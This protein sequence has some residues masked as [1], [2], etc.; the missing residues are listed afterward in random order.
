MTPWDRFK[1]LVIG[2]EKNVRDPRIFHRLSLIAF[3]AWVGLGADGLSSSNYGPQEA[4][5]SLG[6][7]RHLAL[8]LAVMTALTVITISLSYSQIIE[9]FPTGGGGYVVSTKLLGPAFGLVSGCA[10]VVD[11]MLTISISISS[12]V[13]AILS[14]LPPAAF[15]YKLTFILV[16]TLALVLLNLRGVKESVTV[17]TPIFLFFFVSHVGLILFGIFSH[18]SATPTLFAD[19]IRETRQGIQSLGFGAMAFILLRAYSLGGGTYTGIEAV[20]NGL[21]ILRPPRVKTGKKTMLLMA[22]SLSFTAGGLLVCYLLT[23]VQHVAGKTLNASLIE[24]LIGTWKIGGFPLG[25]WLLG[26]ILVSEGAI[27][28]VA[29]QTGFIDG[30]RV[31]GNMAI[32]SWVPNRLMHLSERL[33]VQNGI[34]FMGA[35]A[36]LI[37]LITRG[38]VQTL[39]VMYSINVFLD[40]SLAQLGMCLHWIKTRGAPHRGKKLTINL[41]G[42]L[43]SVSIL[44]VTVAIKFREGGWITLVITLSFIVVCLLIRRHYNKVK[45]MMKRLDAI[46]AQVRQMTGKHEPRVPDESAPT[47]V[48][49]VRNFGGLGIHSFLNIHRIFPNY[50]KNFVFISVGVV[51]WQ[52]FKGAEEVKNLDVHLADE[53]KKYVRMANDFGFHAEAIQSVDIDTLEFVEE[54]CEE[55][56][57]KYN[58]AVFFVGKLVFEEEN[59]F[60]RLLHNQTAFSIQRILQFKGIPSIVLPIRVIK[61]VK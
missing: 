31:L 36:F 35:A 34:I 53:L 57:R 51:D 33:V 4:F 17:L 32:D 12:G 25:V 48:L 40:F 60:T 28:F 10:L 55:I 61:T 38:S 30:P 45:D 26:L 11:Y 44:I 46:M 58:K 7:H 13:E 52:N 21:Q 43:M 18:V 19:T 54:R 50:F 59:A 6:D 29:A 49:F 20:A 23:N 16:I 1:R 37:L 2:G 42:F 9:L 47:A 5:L 15:Q 41:I 3:F 56:Q 27:L 24:T 39:V 14:F 22:A 8:Y